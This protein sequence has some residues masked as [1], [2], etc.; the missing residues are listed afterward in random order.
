M[1]AADDGPQGRRHPSV[2]NID[3]M[4]WQT[5]FEG[6]RFKHGQKRVVGET[7]GNQIGASYYRLEPGRRD[8]P[9]HWHGH[10]EEAMWITKGSGTLRIGE[11]EVAVRPGDWV[12]LPTGADH[13]HQ[14]ISG[15][16]GLEAL[17]L[18]TMLPTEVVV[19]PDSDKVMAQPG[20]F[21]G[22]RYLFHKS[23]GDLGYLEGEF[24][25]E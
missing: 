1:P 16:D 18:S 11:D 22:P 3:E 25:D 15:P 12:S 17:V 5:N 4:E 6:T 23:T 21:P 9:H 24:G 2:V 7:G 10:N 19:Y 13:A 14:L 8:F 20:G